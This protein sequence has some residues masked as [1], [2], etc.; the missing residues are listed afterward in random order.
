VRNSKR[1]TI[2]HHF[3]KALPLTLIAMAIAVVGVLAATGTL[4]SPAGPG[5]T[6]S[7][8]L[9]DVYQRL[10]NGMAGSAS[11]FTEPAVAPGIGTMHSINDLM[12][13]APELDD[14]DGATASEVL[15]G[16]TYWG[17]TNGEWGVQTGT[18]PEGSDVSGLDGSLTIDLPEGYYSGNTATAMDADL[19]A[20]NIKS[21]VEIFGVA[22]AIPEGADVTGREGSLTI[23]LPEGYYVDAEAT[24][25]DSDLLSENIMSGVNI[26][27]V[28][29]ST[30]NTTCTCEGTMSGDRWCDNGDGTVTD[31]LGYYGMGKCLVWLKDAACLGLKP[32]QNP[33][34]DDAFARVAGLK[35][36]VCGLSDGSVIGNWWL[37]SLSQLFHLKVGVDPVWTENMFAF[38]GIG[39]YYWSSNAFNSTDAVFSSMVNLGGYGL[40][41]PRGQRNLVWAVRY[42]F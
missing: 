33:E 19:L 20:G 25:F 37:P 26:F 11:A 14:E 4:D 2:W 40:I 36:G 21:G 32:W 22:G 5:S 38:T 13:A 7:Y 24:A 18:M 29:G 17:L 16:S 15:S 12:A 27:G 8:S 1:T 6:S 31:L 28:E 39:D 35:N 34:G 30:S 42:G 10:T 3:I 9:E 41:D 23:D